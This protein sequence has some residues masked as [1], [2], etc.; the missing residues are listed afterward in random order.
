MATAAASAAELVEVRGDVSRVR[1]NIAALQVA[2]HLDTEAR[3]ATEHEREILGRWSGWGAVPGVFDDNRPEW[4]AVREQLDE[5]LSEEQWRQARRNTLNAHYT[6]PELVTAMWEA[7]SRLGFTPAGA[8]V[9]EPGVGAGAFLAAAPEGA[10]YLGIELDATTAA[11]ARHRFPRAMIRTESFADTRLPDGS[12][13][14]VIG[15]VP[16]GDYALYDPRHNAARHRIHNHF[17]VKGLSLTRPGGLMVAITSRYTLDSASDS[18]RRELAELGD[19]LGA[20]RLPDTAHRAAGTQAVTDIVVFRR[21]EPGQPA[22]TSHDW[23]DLGEFTVEGRTERVNRLFAKRPDL[24]LGDW[25]TAGSMYAGDQLTVRPNGTELGPA[26]RAALAQITTH[27]PV[28]E[29]SAA[30]ALPALGGL[31]R[32]EP[33]GLEVAD[34]PDSTLRRNDDGSFSRAAEGTWIDHLVPK[35]HSTELS[36]L[37]GLRDATVTLLRA[38]ADRDADE[39]RLAE[40]RGD[41]NTRYGAYVEKFGPINR[42]SWRRTGRTDPATGE[43]KLA[44]IRPGQGQFKLD[45]YAPAVYALEHFHDT[46]QTASKADIFHKRVLSPRE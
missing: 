41:L 37:L 44:R 11:I 36:A 31:E 39:A 46:T 27:A 9:L 13:D 40:L 32:A 35:S 24:V 42:F 45:P 15:N 20:V 43:D 4:A 29:S 14:L 30:T 23:L 33:T 22:A 16:F 26:V 7:T 10:R 38:E 19:L 8:T 28:L 18:H 12:V 3:P 17:L 5:L 6:N 21:R 2:R 25:S 34:V 1:A